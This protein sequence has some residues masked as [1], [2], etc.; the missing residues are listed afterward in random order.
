MNTREM[1]SLMGILLCETPRIRS[2]AADIATPV[3]GELIEAMAPVFEKYRATNAQVAAMNLLF[4]ASA[5]RDLSAEEAADLSII[6]S[7]VSK[8]ASDFYAK[9]SLQGMQ[10][11]GKA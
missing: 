1:L 10:P 4:V 7:C 8:A 2:I 9:E 11:K 6:I 5:M 3:V